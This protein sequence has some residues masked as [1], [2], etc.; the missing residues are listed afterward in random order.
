MGLVVFVMNNSCSVHNKTACIHRKCKPFYH[1]YWQLVYNCH[2][3]ATSL[4]MHL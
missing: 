2:K 4:L 1:K 3:F